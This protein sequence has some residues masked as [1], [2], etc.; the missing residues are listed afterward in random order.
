[1]ARKIGSFVAAGNFEVQMQAPAD[2]KQ[3]VCTYADLISETHW[4]SNDGAVY[5]YK[6]FVVPVENSGSIDLYMLI[7]DPTT[8][9]DCYTDYNNWKKIGSESE[10]YVVKNVLNLDTNNV[11]DILGTYAN[12]ID[13]Y[14]KG[15][16]FIAF[17]SASAGLLLHLNVRYIYTSSPIFLIE[18]FLTDTIYRYEI[19][20]NDKNWGTV[21]KTTKQ[22]A[23]G[24]KVITGLETATNSPIVIGGTATKPSL[25]VK[26]NSTESDITLYADNQNGLGAQINNTTEKIGETLISNIDK[27]IV[28]NQDADNKYRLQVKLNL[29]YDSGTKKIN[30]YGKNDNIVVSSIDASDFIKDGMLQ[31]VALS[32]NNLVFTFNTDAG[33]EE[34]TVDLTKFIDVYAPGNGLSISGKTISIKR[35]T[36]SESYLTV[37]S[38]GIKVSG[39]DSA[40]ESMITQAL[41][42]HDIE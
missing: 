38:G 23:D 17:D 21:T 15:K 36:T 2:A 8:D 40:I 18:Y 34:I 14:N 33:A 22:F 6:G 31:N 5:L 42:I 19:K 12:V 35:D 26:I 11:N 24:S 32:G 3:Q 16:A 20:I 30:L 10:V 25:G 28:A 1:M 27:F 37:G 29:K 13:A 7:A 9:A 41:T 4:Q 39:I